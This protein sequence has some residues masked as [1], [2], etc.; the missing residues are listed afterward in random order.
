MSLESLLRPRSIAVIGASDN[1][2]RIGGVPVDLLIRA[3]FG[4]LYA[5]NPKSKTVQGL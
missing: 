5:V 1:P 3:N 2:K 4:K